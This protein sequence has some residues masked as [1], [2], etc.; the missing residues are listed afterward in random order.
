M[1]TLGFRGFSLSC[2]SNL[3]VDRDGR[4]VQRVRFSHNFRSPL[5]LKRFPYK[6]QGAEPAERLEAIARRDFPASFIAVIA[7][8][9]VLSIV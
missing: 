7:L 4:V 9:V 2:R 6:K 1:K 5:Y 8:Q 3:Y